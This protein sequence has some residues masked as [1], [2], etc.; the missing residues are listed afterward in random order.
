M[1]ILMQFHTSKKACSL[2]TNENNLLNLQ[3]NDFKVDKLWHPLFEGK[4]I[5]EML[6][7]IKYI[8]F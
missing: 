5:N 8:F 4:Q 2:E 6:T 7:L 3:C 1:Y